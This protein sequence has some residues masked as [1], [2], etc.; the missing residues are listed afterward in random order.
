MLLGKCGTK[1]ALVLGGLCGYEY[2]FLVVSTFA[3]DDVEGSLHRW[4]RGKEHES[5]AQDRSG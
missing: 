1:R 4:D 5:G 3:N 2:R